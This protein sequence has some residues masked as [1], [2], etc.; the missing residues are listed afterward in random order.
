MKRR[1]FPTI[2]AAVAVML[3]SAQTS[4]AF[5]IG[6]YPAGVAANGIARSRHNLSS[7]GPVITTDATT[8]ICVFCHTPHKASPSAPLWNKA[9]Q[10][11]SYTAYGTT[12]AGTVVG[13]PGGSSLACLSC[14]DGVNT[15]DTLANT[16]GAGGITGGTDRGWTFFMPG[17]MGGMGGGGSTDWD[18]FD[19]GDGGGGGM[20]GGGGGGM[21]T[22]DSCHKMI[23]DGKN[24]ALRL[25]VGVDMARNHPVSVTYDDANP[26]AGLRPV[27]TVIGSID[28]VDGLSPSAFTIYNGNLA[29]NRWA[30]KGKISDASTIGDLLRDGKVECVSCHDP[31]F[32][33]LSWDEVEDSWKG[34]WNWCNDTEECT[35]GNF[36]RRVGGNTGSGMC[37][38]CHTQ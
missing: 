36:L 16:P 1:L 35:D 13:A 29:Q 11:T 25:S 27:T 3:V 14:H 17:D 24:P 8:E 5:T 31:H 6:D 22:C 2:L 37:R 21:G 10:S 38:T 19:T 15:F 33:N 7:T 12:T 34:G 26:L 30:V 23:G 18:H 4:P 9:V 20:G 28:L 32:K